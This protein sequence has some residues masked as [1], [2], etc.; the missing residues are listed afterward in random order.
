L[1]FSANIDDWAKQHL[2][3]NVGPVGFRLLTNYSR[4][5]TTRGVSRDN[6]TGA[7]MM[8]ASRFMRP[9]T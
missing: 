4:E 1:V 6:D 8:L 3:S 5:I 2:Q 7:A 9:S